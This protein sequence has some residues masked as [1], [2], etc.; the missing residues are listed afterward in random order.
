MAH[1]QTSTLWDTVMSKPSLYL[2]NGPLGAGK[3]TLLKFLLGTKKFENA[4][5]IENEFA[6]ADVDAEQLKAHRA[7][8]RSIAGV[9]I[10]CSTGRELTTALEELAEASSMPVIVEAS[11]VA[12]SLALIEKLTAT[13]LFDYYELR[14]AIF[15]LDAAE[16]ITKPDLLDNYR[17]ELS[18]ADTVFLSKTDLLE[19]ED[20]ADLMQQL[21]AYREGRTESMYY[22][23]ID[24]SILENASSILEF[25]S[26][27]EDA[28]REHDQEPSYTI[29]NTTKKNISID[30]LHALWP[31][32]VASYGAER[33]K[34]AVIQ[35]NEMWRVD[36]TP[37]QCKITKSVDSSESLNLVIIGSEASR[38]TEDQII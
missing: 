26:K 28:H 30:K 5:V 12:S 2:I 33:M 6:S 16:V 14:H 17:E 35:D 34:G 37:S 1:L 32:L 13:R 21:A 22:G 31:S 7:E 18:A 11:G 8:V 23:E 4:R 15:V 3:T 24:T 25:Y 29:I 20:A 10:C 27:H 36:A 38:I 19:P 9:C